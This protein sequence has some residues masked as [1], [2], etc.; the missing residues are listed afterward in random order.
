MVDRFN[1]SSRADNDPLLLRDAAVWPTELRHNQMFRRKGKGGE[2]GGDFESLKELVT[3]N[4]EIRNALI[5]AHQYL[6][7]K[8]DVD[9]FRI[10]T[11]KF[12]EQD[13]ARIFDNAMREFALS[14][15]KKNFFT[16]GEVFDGEE[17]IAK[18]IGR[19]ATESSDLVGVDAALDFPLFFTLPS[20]IK[21]FVPPSDVVGVFERRKQV[22]RGII[23]T[24]GDASRFFVSFLDNHDMKNRLFHRSQPFRRS[25]HVGHCLPVFTAGYSVP[26]LRNGAGAER[27][28]RFGPGGA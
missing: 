1:N 24:H 5:R 21:G 3:A 14:I 12:I 28:R 13:F 7:A 4:K 26:L 9:G 16:F 8:F 20:V 22:Q 23:S 17:K 18:F 6:I 10:D 15:G 19:Q 25:G 2:Q 27:C 11:L